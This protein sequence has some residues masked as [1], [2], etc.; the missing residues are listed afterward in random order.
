MTLIRR[1]TVFFSV[2]FV[3]WAILQPV[4]SALHAQQR[5]VQQKSSTSVI[6]SSG[7]YNPGNF[8]TPGVSISSDGTPPSPDAI[9]VDSNATT[10]SASAIATDGT[11]NVNVQSTITENIGGYTYVWAVQL[12]N[13][14]GNDLGTQYFDDNAV[15]PQAGQTLTMPLSASYPDPGDGTTVNVCLFRYTADNNTAVHSGITPA[16]DVFSMNSM[17]LVTPFQFP[18]SE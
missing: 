12:I 15:V 18:P 5:R 2:C 13:P 16:T 1:I 7:V 8:D 11:L 3:T 6:S 4:R 17:N 14:D 9:P 10:D